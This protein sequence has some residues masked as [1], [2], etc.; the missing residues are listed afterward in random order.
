M[1]LCGVTPELQNDQTNTVD[2]S[3]LSERSSGFEEAETTDFDEP[4]PTRRHVDK[5]EDGGDSFFEMFV[6]AAE[7]F[8]S[9]DNEVCSGEFLELAI[10]ALWDKARQSNFPDVPYLNDLP[11]K[12]QCQIIV[13]YIEELKEVVISDCISDIE[14]LAALRTF[15]E[16][17]CQEMG[18]AE[19]VSDAVG[20]NYA[21]EII[22]KGGGDHPT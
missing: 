14:K 3:T 1:E 9:Q 13:E 18:L 19:S 20:S 2:S 11:V 22:L 8:L 7:V 5:R 12:E 16:S 6:I 4:P 10:S 15:A 21:T 17:L